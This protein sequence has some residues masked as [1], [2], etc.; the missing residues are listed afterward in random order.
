MLPDIKVSLPI[1][2]VLWC[3]AGYLVMEGPVLLIYPAMWLAVGVL[4][5]VVSK[6]I[7]DAPADAG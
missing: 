2:F 5:L 6:L 3:V 7:G 4:F 1:L